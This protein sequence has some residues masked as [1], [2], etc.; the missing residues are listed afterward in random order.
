MPIPLLLGHRG[1]RKV[2]S[3]VENTPE[4]FDSSLSQ[5]CDG[6]EFDLRLSGDGEA[7]VCHDARIGGMEIGACSSAKLGLP[8]FRDILERYRKRA[9][10]DIEL[11]MA[12]LETLVLDLLSRFPP[13]QGYVISSFLPKV[14]ERIRGLDNGAPLGLICETPSQFAEWQRLP[15]QYVIPHYKLARRSVIKR[16]KAGRRKVLVWTV[17]SADDMT[18]FTRWNVDGIISDDPEKLVAT[19]RKKSFP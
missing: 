5:G 19:V 1:L 14:L 11:K 18:R 15:V 16:L 7:V 2:K 3:I 4:A 13:A 12:G 10:L 8:F 17:N 6:F 9:F